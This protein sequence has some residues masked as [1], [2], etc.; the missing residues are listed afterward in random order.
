M[1]T[2]ANI[3]P[4][5]H[6]VG[7]TAISF[8]LKNIL[9][10][11]FGR[12]VTI[13]DYPATSKH[14][15]TSKAGLSKQTIHEIN[16]FADGVIVG[17]GNLF[18]NDE[19][20]INPEALKNLKTPLML[21]SNSRGRIYGRNGKLEERTD[22]IPDNKLLNLVKTSTI[23]ASRDTATHEY[24]K[25]L[26]CQDELGFCPTINLSNYEKLLPELPENE[27]VGA[28][29]SIRTPNLMNLP[30]SKQS[31]VQSD[32]STAI[33]A[34]RE[35]G[36]SRIR[37]LCNDSRDLDF[38]V[39]F[40]GSMKVDPIYTND[41]Y[42]YLALINNASIIVSYRLHA[43]LPAVSFGTPVVNITYDERAESICK[44]FDILQ[45]S[46]QIMSTEINVQD[47]IKKKIFEGGYK[48]KE[49]KKR[50]D[51][52]KEI[53]NKQRALFDDFKSHVE[54]YVSECKGWWINL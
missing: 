49:D 34:L 13:I 37:V 29:I 33:D 52:W 18:E 7:N 10:D 31:S 3:R 50:Q 30:I 28:L 47:E 36:H 1:Y 46:I 11:T 38:A 42:Q 43:T 14:E 48:S 17:G 32:I 23:S 54:R 4:F 12:L 39:Q 22:V 41:V 24:I 35:N 2:I 27:H 15:S 5:G 19:I 40:K 51:L 45:N 26:G 6:N 9:Y 53:T 20:D 16:R 25:S 44:D 21:F 8:A